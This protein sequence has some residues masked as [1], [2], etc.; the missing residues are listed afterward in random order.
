MNFSK[1]NEKS[2]FNNTHAYYRILIVKEMLTVLRITLNWTQ[3]N[4]IS[5]IKEYLKYDKNNTIEN[6][7]AWYCIRGNTQSKLM[8]LCILKY[9][10]KMSFKYLHWSFL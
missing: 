10:M 7:D 1:K 6:Q 3:Q 8:I 9:C 4:Y 5:C 2:L